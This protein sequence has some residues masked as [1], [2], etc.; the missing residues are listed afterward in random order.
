MVLEKTYRRLSTFRLTQKMDFGL[1]QGVIDSVRGLPLKR[2]N[3]QTGKGIERR[4]ETIIFEA[5]LLLDDTTR[6]EIFH[7]HS[8]LFSALANLSHLPDSQHPYSPNRHVRHAHAIPVKINKQP[9]PPDHFELGPAM[10]E[11]SQLRTR[12]PA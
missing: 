1:V 3:K 2:N 12:L 8:E 10:I 11:S 4:I 7:T 6:Y 5:G 9:L